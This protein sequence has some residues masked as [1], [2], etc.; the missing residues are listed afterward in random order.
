[1]TATPHLGSL[2]CTALCGI[3]G[4][5]YGTYT[6]AGIIKLCE[7]LKGSSVTSLRCARF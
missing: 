4:D 3:D 2:A 1:M 6:A 7:G 5:L